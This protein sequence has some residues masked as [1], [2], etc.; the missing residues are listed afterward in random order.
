MST[1]SQVLPTNLSYSPPL[2]PCD[3]INPFDVPLPSSTG[4][5]LGISAAENVPLPINFHSTA[6]L[7]SGTVAKRPAPVNRLERCRFFLMEKKSERA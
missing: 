6:A 4:S 7:T 5:K 3:Y 1:N 2:S